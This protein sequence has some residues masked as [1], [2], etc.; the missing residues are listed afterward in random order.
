MDTALPKDEPL[1]VARSSTF[2]RQKV[3][4]V[5]RQAITEGRFAPGTRLVERELCQLTGVS[6][7]S[8]REA[9][10]HLE[11]EGLVKSVANRG[12]IVAELTIDDARAVYDIREALES[13]AARRF[14]ELATD[15][16]VEQLQEG[17]KELQAALANGDAAAMRVA[18]NKLYEILLTGCRNSIICDVILGLQA[19]VGFLRSKSVSHPGRWPLSVAEMEDIVKAIQR[20]DPTAAEQASARHVRNACSAALAVMQERHD[21]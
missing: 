7:T 3:V 12:P 18:T 16:E 20:R 8:V 14:A 15:G 17:Q 4:D 11:A 2:L 19:R 5:L 21:G 9:L 1:Y 13:L 6:R 10:R